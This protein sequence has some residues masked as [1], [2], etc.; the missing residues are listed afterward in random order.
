MHHNDELSDLCL[1]VPCLL[2]PPAA[3]GR[4]IP[5]SE[6]PSPLLG[7]ASNKSCPIN[8]GVKVLTQ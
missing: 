1:L 5:R 6:N 3:E 2:C 7:Q 8:A 4:R